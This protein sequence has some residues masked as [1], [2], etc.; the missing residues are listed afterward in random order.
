MAYSTTTPYTTICA[1]TTV[2]KHVTITAIPPN[3]QLL[4]LD[5]VLVDQVEMSWIDR[6]NKGT[7]VLQV[8]HTSG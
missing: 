8:Y 1:H 7:E 2:T 4:M 6:S 3:S 5:W